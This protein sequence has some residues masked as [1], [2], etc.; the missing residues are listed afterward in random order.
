MSVEAKS[1]Q[2]DDSEPTP[3]RQAELRAAY[4]ANVAAGK[5][6]YE[7]VHIRTRGELQWVMRER[8]WT[9]GD[10]TFL[11]GYDRADLTGADLRGATLSGTDLGFATLTGARLDGADLTSADLWQATLTG[12]RLWQA[13]LRGANLFQAT[14]RGATLGEANLTGAN[15]RGADLTGADLREATLTGAHLDGATLTGADLRE[16][17]LT[18]TDLRKATLT[19]ADLRAARMDATT[20]L[21]EATLDS[22]T[23]LADVGW[24]GVPVTR[25]NWEDVATLGDVFVAQQPKDDAGKKKDMATRL[26]EY[27]DAVMANRQVATVLRDQGLNEHADRFAYR[28]QVLQRRVLRRQRRVGQYAFWR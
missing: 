11:A 10:Y 22:R 12:A 27:Q 6:P 20:D 14:L 21:R 23:Q 8:K 25:L 24:N 7:G 3:E 26:R 2:P 15:L 4:E 1:D 5:A 18:G 9:G 13:T 19:G 28:A 17:T 16:A